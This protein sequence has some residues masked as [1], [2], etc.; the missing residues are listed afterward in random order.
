M[1]VSDMMPRRDFT[2]NTNAQTVEEIASLS[3]MS[4]PV[5]SKFVQ[6]ALASGAVVK[7]WRRVPGSRAVPVYLP[8][9][10]K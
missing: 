8:K 5:A 7:K 4:R 10:K 9:G 6:E 3:G 2:T 1:K